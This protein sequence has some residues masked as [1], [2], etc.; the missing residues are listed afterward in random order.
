M[1]ERVT[2]QPS[3]ESIKRKG[4]KQ[5]LREFFFFRVRVTKQPLEGFIEIKGY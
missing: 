3:K 1:K 2:K 5:P 4:C